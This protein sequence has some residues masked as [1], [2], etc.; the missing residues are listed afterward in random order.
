MTDKGRGNRNEKEKK[1][2]GKNRGGRKQG[3]KI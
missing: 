1:I 3:E 2:K